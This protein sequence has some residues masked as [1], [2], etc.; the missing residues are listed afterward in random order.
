MTEGSAAPEWFPVGRDAVRLLRDGTQAFPAMLDAI[1][2]AA[3]EVLLEMYWIGADAVGERFREA[4]AARARAGV[5]VRVLYD[6][7]GS[8]TISR[9][10]WKPLLEAGGRAGAFHA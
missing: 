6:A 1:A 2:G 9:A 5:E 8:M 7:V 3:R 10:W 4:L